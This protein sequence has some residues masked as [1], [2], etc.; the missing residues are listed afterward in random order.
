MPVTN[1]EPRIKVPKLPPVPT[2][3]ELLHR[4]QSADLQNDAHE[5]QV[6]LSR[7]INKATNEHYRRIV[8]RLCEELGLSDDEWLRDLRACCANPYDHSDYWY[9]QWGH[10]Q[11]R[12]CIPPTPVPQR[13]L[14]ELDLT[15]CW[16][17]LG[18]GEVWAGEWKMYS[19]CTECFNIWKV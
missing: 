12:I 9:D 7:P 19:P 3:V 14:R 4:C 6:V 1:S 5:L 16:N 8:R 18:D 17:C 15:V 2:I 10:V 11:C 13:I